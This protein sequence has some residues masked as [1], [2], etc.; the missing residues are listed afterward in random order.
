MA[1]MANLFAW[2]RRQKNVDLTNYYTKK[3][4]DEILK[5]YAKLVDLDNYYNKQEINEKL[6]DIGTTKFYKGEIRMFNTEDEFNNFNQQ[7]NLILGQDYEVIEAGR[8]LLT[9]SFGSVGGSNYI[10]ENN[11][12]FKQ[13]L[14]NISS[15]Y[16]RSYGKYSPQVIGGLNVNVS[17]STFQSGWDIQ[18]TSGVSGTTNQVVWSY[19][20]ENKQEFTPSFKSVFVIKFLKD[21]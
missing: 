3:Q 15:L 8:Y 4:V 18:S 11:L 5:K 6:K 9:G 12:P 14:L 21:V 16:V 2:G 19:G 17:K 10:T 13:Y 1:K 7:F 20:S